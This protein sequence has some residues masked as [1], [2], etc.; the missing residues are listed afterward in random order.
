MM[1]IWD[2]LGVILLFVLVNRMIDG[3]REGM[4]QYHT[5]EAKRQ[6]ELMILLQNRKNIKEGDVS[7]CY[8]FTGKGTDL[9]NESKRVI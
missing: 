2:V 5:E 4:R 8:V 3:F 1:N 7:G 9:I 6:Q